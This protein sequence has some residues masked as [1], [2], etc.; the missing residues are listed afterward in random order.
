MRA[1]PDAI[2]SARRTS[3]CGASHFGEPN[4]EAF[5]YPRALGVR[6]LAASLVG[7]TGKPFSS[8][9]SWLSSSSS[10]FFTSRDRRAGQARYRWSP[11]DN[12]PRQPRYAN[13]AIQGPRPTDRICGR[14]DHAPALSHAGLNR[15]TSIKVCPRRP[16]SGAASPIAIGSNV[17][18]APVVNRWRMSPTGQTGLLRRAPV[19]TDK[20]VSAHPPLRDQ[21]LLNGEFSPLASMASRSLPG[22]PAHR[23]NVSHALRPVSRTG[24]T[25]T[26]VERDDDYGRNPTRPIEPS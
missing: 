17:E 14:T 21:H 1:L 8:G 18:I 25:E 12:S 10:R 24:Y 4:V 23:E 16:H 2:V 7:L 9:L 11:H 3:R 19:E 20:H 15:K 13:L 6:S 26:C 5:P 22:M